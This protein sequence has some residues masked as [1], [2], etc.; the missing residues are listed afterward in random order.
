MSKLYVNEIH[1]QSGTVVKISGSLEFASGSSFTIFGAEG[2]AANLILKADEGDDLND[3]LTLSVAA[4]GAAT[5]TGSSGI[6]FDTSNLIVS[7][8]I[9]GI[10]T[11]NPQTIKK[12]TIPDNHNSVLWGPVT[13][14]DDQDMIIGDDSNVKIIDITDQ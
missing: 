4:N 1:P 8:N 13:I 2:S 6:T 12:V 9:S 5:L 3:T 14:D 11:S 10:G 7:G